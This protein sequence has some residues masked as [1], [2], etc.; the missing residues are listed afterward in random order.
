MTGRGRVTLKAEAEPIRFTVDDYDRLRNK[1]KIGQRIK[2]TKLRED[3]KEH[4]CTIR[5]TVTVDKLYP[6][7]VSCIND[8]G[9]RESF[10][11]FELKMMAR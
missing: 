10:G 5:K 9:Q 1:Y 8:S 6:Y 3:G 11:Y 4:A 7:H 2:V